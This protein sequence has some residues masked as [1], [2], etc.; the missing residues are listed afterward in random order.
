MYFDRSLCFYCTMQL[1]QQLPFSPYLLISMHAHASVEEDDFDQHHEYS[2]S[3]L[4]AFLRRN[5]PNARLSEDAR[6]V[7]SISTVL[8]NVVSIFYFFHLYFPSSSAALLL[9]V[10][11]FLLLLLLLLFEL[12]LFFACI[13]TLLAPS[14]SYSGTS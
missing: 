3:A 2:S 12:L 1:Q 10:L 9:L 14:C 5:L 13:P 11:P 7:S 4:D 8:S 6:Y